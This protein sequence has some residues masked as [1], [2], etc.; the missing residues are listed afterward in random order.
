VEE[1]GPESWKDTVREEI[2]VK[3]WQEK[4]GGGQSR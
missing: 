1:G 4:L 3:D 2:D